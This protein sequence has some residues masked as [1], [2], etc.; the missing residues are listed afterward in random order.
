MSDD[1]RSLAHDLSEAPRKAQRDVVGVVEHG[2]L[3]VKNGW[4]DNAR[5]SSGRHAPAYPASISYTLSLGAAL[6]GDV[7]A[8]IGPDKSKP[9]GPL[10]NLLEFGSPHSAPHNDGGR[11]LQVEASKFEEALAA[12]TLD[13]LGWH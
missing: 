11:A 12:V 7:T 9:Q 6:A 8:E 1:L 5:Q 10:G 4:A 13:A 2:A 3:N